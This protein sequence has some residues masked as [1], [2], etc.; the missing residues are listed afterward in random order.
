MATSVVSTTRE[1]LKDFHLQFP[2]CVKLENLS[3][4]FKVLVEVYNLELNK[5][6]IDHDTKYHIANKKVIKNFIIQS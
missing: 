5:Q 4:D 6:L 3:S 2:G 1:N